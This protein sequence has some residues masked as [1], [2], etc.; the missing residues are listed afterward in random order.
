MSELLVTNRLVGALPRK[1]VSTYPRTFVLLT[2]E[3]TRRPRREFCALNFVSESWPVEPF[4]YGMLAKLLP[5]ELPVASF[6]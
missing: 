2:V 4:A 3:S 6:R 1:S 5:I